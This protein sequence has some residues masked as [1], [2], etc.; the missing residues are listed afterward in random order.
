[1][2]DV[3][4]ELQ[5]LVS[6]MQRGDTKAAIEVADRIL[7]SDPQNFDALQLRALAAYYGRDLSAALRDIERAISL[8]KDFAQAF[9]TYGIILKAMG[10][11]DDAIRQFEAALQRRQSYPE[12]L[13]NIG[14][15]HHEKGSLASA[16]AFYE[17]ALAQD[18]TLLAAL[19]NLGIVL[20]KQKNHAAALKCFDQAIRKQPRFAEGHYNRGD[21]LAALG[22]FEQAIVSYG[23]ALQLRPVFPAAHCNRANALRL[24]GRSSEALADY[25]KAILQ[26]RAFVEAHIGKA[27]VLNELGRVDDALFCLDAALALRP[28]LAEAHSN[29]GNALKTL[30]RLDEALA[31]YDRAIALKPDYAEAYCNRGKV[32][33]DLRRLDDALASYERAISLRPDY[34]EAYSNR[35]VVLNEQGRLDE[36]LES[37]SRAMT[38]E[39]GNASAWLGLARIDTEAGRF[40]EAEAKYLK[41]CALDPKAVAPLCGLAG[42]KKFSDGDPLIQEFVARLAEPSL[43]ADDR[44]FL[45]H[46]YAKI[47]NDLGRYDDA[48]E[49]F[50]LGKRLLAPRFNIN[51]HREK[52]AALKNLFTRQFFADRAGLGV[53]DERPVFIVGMPRSGTTLTEQILASHP[54]VGGLGELPHMSSLAES[55]GSGL[56]DPQRFATEVS[57]LGATDI[58]CLAEVYREAYRACDPGHVRLVDKMPHNF[59]WLGLIA[60][61]FPKAHVIHCRRNPLDN[62]VSIFMQSYIDTHDYAKDLTLLGEYYREYESLMR[63]W[64]EVLPIQIHDCVYEDTVGDMAARTRALLAFLQLD[65]DANCLNFHQQDSQVRTA[66]S[67]QVR[68]PVFDTSIGRWR[69]YERHLK[70]LSDA[71]GAG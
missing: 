25:D 65:W 69:R 43:S 17:K 56:R 27:A 67:W 24:L 11:H 16:A 35:G 52:H 66:S 22:D 53:P 50:L 1:M 4:V 12:A 63:H 8:R 20:G 10:R 38:L 33:R 62:C 70:P 54:R 28:K 44:S 71:L 29:R 6:N 34:A 60:L 18:G 45:H 47:C 2:S 42:V 37:F 64:Q 51:R 9:N 19:N 58:A 5:K 21:A 31:S 14:N 48:M 23:N 49:H 55:L 15:C 59:Q 61:L 3:A 26:D 7:T 41:S 39:P 46:S 40:A 13:Y 36:A 30:R 68:Q 32:Q 57:A